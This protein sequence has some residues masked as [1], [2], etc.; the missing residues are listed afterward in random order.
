MEQSES[1]VAGAHRGIAR[2]YARADVEVEDEPFSDHDKAAR[3]SVAI[4]NVC[5]ATSWA[6]ARTFLWAMSSASSRSEIDRVPCGWSLVTSVCWTDE[7]KRERQSMGCVGAVPVLRNQ[8]PSMPDWQASQKPTNAGVCS[9]S[10][11]KRVGRSRKESAMAR[12][13]CAMCKPRGVMRTR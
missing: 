9:T 6:R 8:T 7:G 13:S 12:K 10:S 5:S 1:G 11:C 2:R 4:H 3:L